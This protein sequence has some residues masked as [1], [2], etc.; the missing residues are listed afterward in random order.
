MIVNSQGIL[1]SPPERKSPEE[2]DMM[3]NLIP[4]RK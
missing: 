3:W 4:E 1:N 2:V